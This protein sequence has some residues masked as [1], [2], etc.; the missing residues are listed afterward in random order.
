MVKD[1]S[2][3]PDD[4]QT[5]ADVTSDNSTHLDQAAIDA[6]LA[7]ADDAG[8]H[9]P[10]T[11]DPEARPP[12]ADSGV[13]EQH[14]AEEVAPGPQEDLLDQETLDLLFASE[15]EASSNLD[16]SQVEALLRMQESVSSFEA[17]RPAAPPAPSPQDAA[18]RSSSAIQQAEIDALF[19]SGGAGLDD[20]LPEEAVDPALLAEAE[21][22]MA[23]GS[24]AP[25]LGP[26]IDQAE[27]DQL[28]AEADDERAH[29][30]SA[31]RQ[32][33]EAAKALENEP[34][35]ALDPE[36][37][38]TPASALLDEG[39]PEGN[40]GRVPA[41]IASMPLEDSVDE[42]QYPDLAGDE[43]P[44]IPVGVEDSIENDESDVSDEVLAALMAAASGETAEEPPDVPAASYDPGPEVDVQVDMADSAPR[45]DVEPI[46]VA[47][48]LEK[49]PS[50]WQRR[51][52][53]IP[54]PGMNPKAFA[55]LTASIAAGL[56]GAVSVFAGLYVYQ[57]R[58]PEMADLKEL[59]PSNELEASMANARTLLTHGDA[60][61]AA[62]VLE[63]PLGR[64][65]L[66]PALQDAEILRLEALYAALMPRPVPQEAEIFLGEAD[67]VL[68]AAPAHPR[69]PEILFWQAKV[70]ESL[71]MRHA[72]KDVYGKAIDLYGDAP[73]LDLILAEAA[74]LEISMRATSEATE[75]ARRLLQQFPGSE[76]ADD[77]RL[78]L[79][80]AYNQANL[81]DEAQ[82]IYARIAENESGNALGAEAYLRLA[83]LALEQGDAAT[84][85]E[86]LEERLATAM[87]TEGND[88][89]YLMLG[90]AQQRA[91]DLDAAVATFNDV[92]TFFPASAVL[93]RAYVELSQTYDDQGRRDE[94]IRIARQAAARYPDSVAALTNAGKLFG[95]AGD[96][97]AAAEALMAADA[98]GANAPSLLLTAARHFQTAG[99]LDDARN[100][101]DLL[102]LHYP[103]SAEAVS[104]SIEEASVMYSQG[105]VSAAV[106]RLENLLL[107][108][109]GAP[110]QLLALR[111]LSGI[112]EDLGL[113]SRV[114]ELTRDAALISTEPE[115]LAE[116]AHTLLRMGNTEEGQAVAQRLSLS[117]VNDHTAYALLVVQGQA[118]LAGDPQ[119][120]VDLL[121]QAYLRYPQARTAEGDQAL[122]EA[123][124]GTNRRAA[125]RRMLAEI[126]AEAMA[127]PVE[128]PRLLQAAV[129][130]GDALYAVGDHG[131][132]AE[133]YG[134]AAAVDQD[135]KLL[136]DDQARD[137]LW[138]RY[139]RA[140][141]LLE[142]N[143]YQEAFRMYQEIALSGA[144]WA[145]EAA[146]KAEYTRTQ[147]RLRGLPIPQVDSQ[148]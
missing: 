68:A 76:H 138:A 85:I 119:R 3:N 50:F 22:I 91:G 24:A 16:H 40:E 117:A 42:P 1:P 11:P 137:V 104:G 52:T 148:G 110:Q 61:G 26:V 28:L 13:A 111:T 135:G 140:N 98:A 4:D 63:G 122:L 57:E 12:H 9:T 23:A 60:S 134:M 106:D 126:Q 145:K 37:R 55:R 71:D 124:I 27:L 112:Y 116:S 130:W 47:N 44:D 39:A 70:Y 43:V 30:I 29:A 54:G 142:T 123:Y 100:A 74:R 108:L 34:V 92:I 46:P 67:R 20:D 84:A 77:A 141:M 128:S 51:R 18:S 103:R 89:V 31:Q 10:P 121:E 5:E 33:R 132:A 45:P 35:V 95:L 147:L 59:S 97:L 129:T 53:R 19:A 66:S 8:E 127:N 2:E 56:L 65:P 93:P 7:D 75:H 133:A 113:Q 115:V 109:K 87:T 62:S 81:V 80:D 78:L 114:Q 36:D 105:Q 6:L 32:E 143:D 125:A 15:S 88:R 118:M 131:G 99:A 38:L 144:P 17:D 14:P 49:G 64:A 102:R 94:A 25:D 72:A 120:G 58:I 69:A 146:T 73:A 83:E 136:S 21:R 48:L 79:A 101:Y 86:L 139:Q 107:T 41:S 96:P 82:A 90:E